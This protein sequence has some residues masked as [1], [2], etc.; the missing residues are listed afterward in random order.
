MLLLAGWQIA[1]AQSCADTLELLLFSE[2]LALIPWF[3]P[4]LIRRL[5]LGA[6]FFFDSELA[7]TMC[8]LQPGTNW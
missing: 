4:A 1:A 2:L 3:E 7:I 6:V 5:L 8:Q